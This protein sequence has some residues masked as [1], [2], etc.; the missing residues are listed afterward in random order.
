MLA[1]GLLLSFM[2]V[3]G[4][5]N[6]GQSDH[7]PGR[8]ETVPLRVVNWPC[9]EDQILDGRGNYEG[10]GYGRYRCVGVPPRL[11]EKLFAKNR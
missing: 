8:A 4:T 5:A 2:L 3:I 1:V 11:E 7:D 9:A 6:P 10:G